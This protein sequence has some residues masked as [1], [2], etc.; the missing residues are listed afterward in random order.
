MYFISCNLVRLGL[1][2]ELDMM[3]SDLHPSDNHNSYNE[4]ENLRKGV[5]NPLRKYLDWSF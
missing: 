4:K 2:S 1:Y 5:L 3:K